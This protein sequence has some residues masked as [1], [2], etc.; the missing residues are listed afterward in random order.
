MDRLLPPQPDDDVDTS[1]LIA[2]WRSRG[3]TNEQVARGDVHQFIFVL[4]E[5]VM[6]SG[7]VSVEVGL[8]CIDGD[9]TM[10]SL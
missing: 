5:K 7:I 4:D 1:D 2:L 3:L 9:S 8:R 6:V 10:T